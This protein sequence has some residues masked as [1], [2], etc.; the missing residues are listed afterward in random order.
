LENVLQ[1]KTDKAFRASL[2]DLAIFPFVR[3]FAAV[4]QAWFDAEALPAVQ[5]WL[6][7][8]LVSDLFIAIMKK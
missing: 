8:W 3:Q 5:V 6:S 7:R 2:A 4:N 1:A